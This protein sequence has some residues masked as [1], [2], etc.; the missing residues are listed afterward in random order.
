MEDELE[1]LEDSSPFGN[2]PTK[3]EQPDLTVSTDKHPVVKDD[4]GSIVISKLSTSTKVSVAQKM[5]VEEYMDKMRYGITGIAAL[6]CQDD[7]CP[8]Y[9]KCPLVRAQIQRPTGQ[10]CPVE[11]GLMEQW[12]TQFVQASGNELEGLSAYDHLVIQDI[13]YQQLLEVRAAMELADNPN[14]QVR[15]FMGHDPQDG[16]PMFTYQL[17]NLVTF[18]EKSNKMKMKL[19]REL[20]ATAKAKSEEERGN[21]DR[22]SET[23]ERLKRIEEKLGPNA[24]KTIDAKFKVREDE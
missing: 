13:A 17:N 2:L 18:R 4:A 15:T 19:L 1:D 7:E 10:D 6:T 14:I 8:Y 22:S 12:L 21:R 20:I 23:A 16:A 11:A 9:S 3:D 24:I 5:Q